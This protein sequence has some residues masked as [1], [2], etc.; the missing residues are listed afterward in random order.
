[1]FSA[2][3]QLFVLE[4]VVITFIVENV[5]AIYN[6][7]KLLSALIEYKR[8]KKVLKHYSSS[9]FLML[10]QYGVR[11]LQAWA[12]PSVWRIEQQP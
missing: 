10:T 12:S 5:I 9:S 2:D 8:E 3:D 6:P 7:S 4:I 1:M 11:L